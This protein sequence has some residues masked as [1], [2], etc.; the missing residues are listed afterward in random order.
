LKN[1][2]LLV[3]DDVD[4]G[5]T[6]D[7]TLGKSGYEIKHVKS[8]EECIKLLEKTEYKPDLILLDIMMPG[9]NGWEV[10]RKLKENSGWE[11]IPIVF[12]TARVDRTA[13]NAGS[14]LGDDYIEKPYD[15]ED[16]KR[17]IE[18]ILGST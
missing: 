15:P 3:D 18:K 16:L 4:I 10:Y 5:F 17:R 1:K 6:V 2:I 11:K 14:F 7:L 12:L 13:E 8:G 9:M